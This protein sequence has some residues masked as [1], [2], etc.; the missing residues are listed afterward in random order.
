M[1]SEK[2]LMDISNEMNTLLV[3]YKLSLIEMITVVAMFNRAFDRATCEQL[4][5]AKIPQGEIIP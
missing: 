3:G 4:P 1:R 2:E 5:I